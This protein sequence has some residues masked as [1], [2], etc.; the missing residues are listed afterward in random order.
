MPGMADDADTDVRRERGRGE[1]EEE[2][3]G[4]ALIFLRLHLVDLCDVPSPNVRRSRNDSPV[5]SNVMKMFC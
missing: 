5:R 1:E 3:D 4:S 2:E